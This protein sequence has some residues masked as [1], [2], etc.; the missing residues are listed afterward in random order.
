MKNIGILILLLFFS[1]CLTSCTASG[2]RTITI[3]GLGQTFT[4]EDKASQDY[5]SIFSWTEEFANWMFGIKEEK[6]EEEPVPP[7]PEVVP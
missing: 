3:T 1:G 7:I 6:E 5:K 2:S 4:I